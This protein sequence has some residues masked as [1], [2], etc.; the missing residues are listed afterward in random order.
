MNTEQLG[1]SLMTLI[2]AKQATFVWGPAGIGKSDVMRQVSAQY[3][4]LMTTQAE[5]EQPDGTMQGRVALLMDNNP[6]LIDIRASQLD[7]TD[8]RG[9]PKID[10]EYA[11]WLPHDEFP[12]V[13]RD[14]AHGV[15]FLDELPDAP[16]LVKGSLYRLI[17]DRTIG[18]Y[19]L[20]DGW[21][22]MAAGNRQEDGGLYQRMPLPLMNRFT[23]LEIEV[24]VDCW[25]AWAINKLEPEI[26]Q[27]IRWRPDS[28]HRPAD[29]DSKDKAFPTPRS[30]EFASN[31][32]KTMKRVGVNRET[33]LEIFKGTV[34]EAEA[35]ELVGFL[36]IFRELPNP[37]A[38]LLNPDSADIPTKP[39]IL[40]A[41]VGALSHKASKDNSSRI[42]KIAERMPTEFNVMLVRDSVAKS[43]DFQN[44]P[45]FMTWA[46][47]N[48]DVLT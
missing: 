27:Y 38:I 5:V 19:R 37:D 12:R 25:V 33:E 41:L 42:I 8:V 15:L 13:G 6:H 30:W 14:P 45:D 46:T 36:R 9:L 17:L 28:L 26:V 35:V 23:H 48:H 3:G 43:K 18:E 22:V 1:K 34:G 10:G 11:S 20:P 24:S 44:T 29:K 2:L 47:N 16:P 39:E 7:P 4:A 40:Y 31:I 32:L 21:A